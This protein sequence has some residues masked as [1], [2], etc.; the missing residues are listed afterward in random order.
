MAIRYRQLQAPG[1]L[2]AVQDNGDSAAAQSLANSLK[3]FSDQSSSLLGGLRSQQGQ[4][5][6][7]AAGAAGA[8]QFRDGARALTAYGEAYNN[9]ALRSYAVRAEADAEDQAARLETEAANDP[10]HF[11]TTFGAVRD[12]TV[13]NA[14]E[15]A[16]PALNELYGRRLAE[17]VSRLSRAQAVDLRNSARKDTSEGIDRQTDR[18]ANLLAED[19]PANEER[20]AEEQVKL[21]MLVDGAVND[22]TLSKVEGSA[23][24]VG[25][26]RE[27][28]KRTVLARFQKELDN[29]YGDPVKFIKRFKE[30]N[31]TSEA[32]PPEEEQKLE[33]GLL[34]ELRERNALDAASRAQM[35]AEEQARFA[36]GD[37][38]ATSDLLAGRLTQQKLLSMTEQDQLRPE[39]ARTLR[40]ELTS[41]SAAKSDPQTLF[42]Y[43]TDLLNRSEDEIREAPGLTWDDRSKLILKRREWEH[44]WRTTQEGREG[45]DRIDRAL[46]IT[47]GIMSQV[48]PEPQ[49]KA[50]ERALTDWYTAVDALEPGERQKAL[51]P[52]AEEVIGRVIRSNNS[53]ELERLRARR[54]QIAAKVAEEKPT[55]YMKKTV[56]DDIANLDAQIRGLEQR[57]K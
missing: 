27:V 32:L 57:V 43:E 24:H 50:R 18:I 7:A 23:L 54:S 51:I 53:L 3:S 2:D 34:G 41:G 29:P 20:I 11:R 25:A 26:M 37:K 1:L 8:P 9:S 48:L 42:S 13:K 38:E 55:G 56:D 49:R 40:N 33:D 39:T 21:Q 5:E 28:T 15:M 17:G 46:G 4:R 36:A 14:P 22:G 12:T 6:G 45:A 47:P 35:N 16:R 52:Q 44:G 19:N 10:E 31:K 30:A